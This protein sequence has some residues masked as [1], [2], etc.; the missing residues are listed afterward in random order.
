MTI[1]VADVTV[2]QIFVAVRQLGADIILGCQFIDRAVEYVAVQ[3]RQLILVSGA[4]V[5]VVRRRAIVPVERTLPES[6]TLPVRAAPSRNIIRCVK[7]IA[8]S[9][10]SETNVLVSCDVGGTRLIESLPDLYGKK[11]VAMANRVAEIQPQFPFVVRV[12][13]LSDE[14]VTLPKN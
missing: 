2:R 4:V 14:T 3:K 1:T 6:T 9:P 13:N 5:P 7:R 10:Q 8:L 11:M 12:A